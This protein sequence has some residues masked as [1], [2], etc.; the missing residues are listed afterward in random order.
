MKVD[1][2][3]YRRRLSGPD[4]VIDI[5]IIMATYRYETCIVVAL[6]LFH[7]WL[8][9]LRSH[10]GALAIVGCLRRAIVITTHDE[11]IRDRRLPR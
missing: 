5:A 11:D 4:D 2:P 1:T 7:T 8:L 3:A 10:I 9:A 6:L